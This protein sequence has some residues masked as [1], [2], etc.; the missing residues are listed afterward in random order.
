MPI[1]WN[2]FYYCDDNLIGFMRLIVFSTQEILQETVGMEPS[3]NKTVSYDDEEEDNPEYDEEDEE[4]EDY[5]V[6][7]CSAL[8]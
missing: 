4:E 8:V 3:I 6:I 5:K 2:Q 1:I 7:D